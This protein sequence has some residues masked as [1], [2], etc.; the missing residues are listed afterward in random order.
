MADSD[1]SSI[2]AK[3]GPIAA[4]RF[5]EFRLYLE[6]RF[7]FAIASQMQVIVFGIYIFHLTKDPLPLGL[8]CLCEAIPAITI[9]LYGGYNADKSEERKLLLKIF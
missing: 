6:L 9:A 2:L 8:I 4:R 3:L 1:F 7:F 5:K